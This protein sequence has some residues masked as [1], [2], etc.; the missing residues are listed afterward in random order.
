MNT[1]A[2]ASKIAST[3]KSIYLEAIQTSGKHGIPNGHL[4]AMFMGYGIT[5]EIHNAIITALKEN[6][7]VNE[8]YNLL[9]AA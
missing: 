4:Y 9:K 8:S 5:L 2:D 7:S 6:G 3:L 1:Q